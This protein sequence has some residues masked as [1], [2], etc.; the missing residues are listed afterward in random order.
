MKNFRIHTRLVFAAVMLICA[1]T[2]SLGYM[3]IR[4]T[5]GLVQTRL[6]ERMQILSRYLAVNAELGIIIDQRS[7]LKQLALNLLSEKDVVRITI[8]NQQNEILADEAK[9]KQESL[10]MVEE[11]VVL[12]GPR[13]NSQSF[14]L[15]GSDEIHEKRI[16]KVRITYSTAEINK[17]LKTIKI[18]FAWISVAL[19]V[20][21]IIVFYFISR[22]LIAPVTH[23]AQSARRVAE[24][25]RDL[26]ARP[27]SL[28]ETRELALAFNAMLDSLE[29]S[30]Q[31]LWEANQKM[32]RQKT[33]AEIGKFSMMIAH[34]VKNPL[35]ILKSSIDMLKKD[36]C[37]A[38]DNTLVIYMEDEIRRL[39]ALI[40]DFL[41]FARPV[42]P[43]LRCVDL[44]EMLRDIVDR[45]A[46]Q[47]VESDL[48]ISSRI[49]QESKMIDA[50]RDLLTR[51]IG[52][53][54]KNAC[55]ANHEKGI[56]E[57]TAFIG[58][59]TWTVAIR[60]QGEG[61][62]AENMTKIFDPFF[63]TRSKGTGLGLAFALQVIQ[64]HNGIIK[65]ENRSSAGTVFTVR[66]PSGKNIRPIY[67]DQSLGFIDRRSG[68]PDRRCSSSA[69][70]RRKD[71]L[72][73]GC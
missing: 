20:I 19:T 4:I 73:T 10:S 57:I 26:R 6:R 14:L 29:E 13:A 61:I 56:I 15:S 27:G 16:G 32:F 30:R 37:I 71:D 58:Q 40:E 7:L 41:Q 2:F 24:G 39:N 42:Q 60:D 65:A 28:P 23:L 54:I 3:G 62:A 22:S 38:D 12:K 21:S 11:P 47:F 68:L 63:T 64:A 31:A 67:G 18:R 59:G 33:L 9:L 45:F 25:K 5:H 70:Q 72:H 36:F 48:Q 52:N 44:N 35:G 66:L 43:T 49:P 46:V 8:F 55:E 34:E 1:T 53:I 51:A 17:L 69:M 50:D